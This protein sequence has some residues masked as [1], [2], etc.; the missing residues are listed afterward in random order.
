MSCPTPRSQCGPGAVVW[1]WRLGGFAKLAF[2]WAR[3]GDSLE[4]KMWIKMAQCP[5]LRSMNLAHALVVLKAIDGC[6][7]KQYSLVLGP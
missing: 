4:A 2:R 3:P 1:P 5:H 7:L 6:E